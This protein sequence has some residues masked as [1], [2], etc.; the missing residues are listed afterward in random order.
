MLVLLDT[1][2]L[3]SGLLFPGGPS[4][5][6]VSAWRTGAFDLAVSDFLLD[7]LA[8]ILPALSARMSFSALDVKDF[9]DLL[10]AM[11]VAVDLDA[12]SIQQAQDSGLRNPNDV[13][14]L[15]ILATLIQS[16]ADCLV[17]G[18]KDLL[19][20]RVSFAILTPAEFCSRHA[21]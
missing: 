20:L 4:G 5:R 17:S 7:E 16:G 2:V 15:P 9:L 3:V 11:A 18:D 1:N 14:I 21:P 6:I 8:R 19:A 10:Q 12:A 13:P